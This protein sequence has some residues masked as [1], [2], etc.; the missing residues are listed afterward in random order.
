MEIKQIASIVNDSLSETIGESA[1]LLLDD[2]SNVVDVGSQVF[3]ANSYDKFVRSLVDHIGKVVFVARP[4]RGIAPSVM[5]DDWEFG[6]VLEKIDGDVPDAEEN[7][8]WNLEDGQTYDQDKFTAPRVTVKF[9]NKKTTFQVPI[10]I[11]EEQ[12]KSAFSSRTQ[13]NSFI[14]FIF[15]KMEN[16]MTEAFDALV[17]RTIVNMAGETVWDEYKDA[18]GTTLTDLSAKSG[19]RAVNLLKLY[20]DEMGAS[21]TVARALKDPDFLRFA[22]ERIRVTISRIGAASTLFNVGKTKKFTKREELITVMLTDFVS[23]TGTYLQSSTFNDELVS[24]PKYQDVP[25][26][27]G[28]G[29]DYSQNGQFNIKLASD[30]TK[31]VAMTGIMLGVMFDRYALGVNN[32]KKRVRT[33]E[34]A[35]AEFTNYWYKQDA[36]YFNDLNENFVAFF[37]A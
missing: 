36:N 5:M 32:T 18:Q 31:T 35:I 22:G 34:N 11:T 29:N 10:S 37:I 13:L 1:T 19:V 12:V 15:V 23:A 24:L 4:Y 20:N 33:H 8:T 17:M 27:Q 14:S 2:L 30:N 9:W 25:Y 6:A 16:K 26:W 7:P 3:N 28:T 21:L